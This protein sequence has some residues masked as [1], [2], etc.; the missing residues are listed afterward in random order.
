MSVPDLGRGVLHPRPA[1]AVI[2]LARHQPAPALARVVEFYWS[3]R[4]DRRGQPPHEQPVLAHPNVHL[5]FEA[6]VA[7]VYGVDRSLFV[8]RL[9][10]AGRV[11]GVKFRPGAFR[12]FVDR[13]VAELAD[14]S[15][16]AA[17][18]FG[19]AVERL[20]TLVLGSDEDLTV[21]VDDFLLA[22]LPAPDPLAERAA[23]LVEHVTGTPDLHRV[24]QL[25]ERFGLS[26]RAVQR[27]FAEYVGASPKWV[28]RRARLHEAAARAHEGAGVD[29]AA[30]AAE[31]GYA[32]QAHLTRDFTAAVGLSPARYAAGGPVSS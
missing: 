29:W 16:P 12:P 23:A 18:L 11:L 9:A 24:D 28:L 32:D 2:T 19:P 14:R 6:P 17:E 4:W 26:V 22:R 1:A 10:G 30:L 25:A 31:L 3:V 8:R 15:V 21:E 5:V 7:R 13:P 20:N 27:L